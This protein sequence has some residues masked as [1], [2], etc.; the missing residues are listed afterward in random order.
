MDRRFETID[1]RVTMGQSRPQIPHGHEVREH[2]L[3][4]HH[5]IIEASDAPWRVSNLG[6][7][8]G[9]KTHG[10]EVREGRLEGHHGTI[11]SPDTPW[12]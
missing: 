11:E 4:S 12:T 9:V 1:W 3:E 5:G 8:E 2:R 6:V 10:E 7:S